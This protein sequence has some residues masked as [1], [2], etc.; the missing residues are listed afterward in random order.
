M[1]RLNSI[2]MIHALAALAMLLAIAPA[3]AQDDSN[4]A[5]AP[6]PADLDAPA[7][8]TVEPEVLEPDD[9]RA[10]SD[11]DID[12]TFDNSN[13]SKYTTQKSSDCCDGGCDDCGCGCEADC[14]KRHG[15]FG[16]IHR[17]MGGHSRRGACGGCGDGCSDGCGCD[18]GA[19]SG[20]G[21]RDRMT[22]EKGAAHDPNRTPSAS[23]YLFQQYYA[24]A[25]AGGVAAQMYVAPYP[26]PPHVGHTYITYQAFEPSQFLYRHKRKYVRRFGPAGGET[27]TCIH[28][29]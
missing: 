22:F 26:V 6:T 3:V 19:C 20:R 16:G 5:D 10:I 28:W 15:L 14:S 17:L 4:F 21:A 24:P 13:G 11:A 12:Y 18:G 1:F 27:T 8:A 25:V 2:R 7:P 29:W 23:G 9:P